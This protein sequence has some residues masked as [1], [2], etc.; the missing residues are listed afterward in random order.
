M[1]KLTLVSLLIL[2]MLLAACAPIA[3]ASAPIATT[4]ADEAQPEAT[5]PAEEEVAAALTVVRVGYIPVT[6]YAPLYVADAKGYL[7]EEGIDIELMPVQGGSDNVVQVGAGNFDVAGGGISAGMWN[8]AD[9]GIEFEI[10]LPLHAERPPL[11]TPLVVSKT[12]F[13]NGEITSVA[14]LAG[15][16]VAVNATGAATE[17]WLE[18]ALEQGDLTLDDVELTSVGFRE[19]A[20]ALENGS[21]DAGMLGEPLTTLAEDQGLIHR[22]TDDFLS[23]FTVTVVYY[24]KDWASANPE[25]ADGFAKAFLRGARDLVGDAWFDAENLAIIEEYTGVPA[26]VVGRASRSYHDPNGDVPAEDL[27]I[28]QQFF[29][30]RGTLNYDELIDV[31]QYINRS[32]AEKAVEELGRIDE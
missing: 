29:M 9:R 32:Y 11:T 1:R 13:D 2:M 10:A 5:A 19:V 26:D 30:D 14:D 18:K 8:A 20:A 3:P 16:K 17:Y 27:M 7:A 25:L 4:P 6:I 23:D 12:R 28:L 24:N 21:L 15:K 31:E 22:L